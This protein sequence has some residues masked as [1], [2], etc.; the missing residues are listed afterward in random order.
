MPDER[1]AL[2]ALLPDDDYQ[3][4]KASCEVIELTPREFMYEMDAPIDY[5]YFPR[6]LVAS[7]ITV[8][9]DG[10]MAEF[11]TIGRE[12]MV[13]IPAFLGATRAAH[14]AF[15]QVPGETL[16][17]PTPTLLNEV[18]H[19]SALRTILQLY[20]Q[21]LFTQVAQHASCRSVHS[22]E[23]RAAK[24]LLMSHDRVG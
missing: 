4:L 6:S 15:C 21:A 7:M 23:E 10:T 8:M 5:V 16:R 1:N 18:A 13:G 12:G 3:R 11:A 22:V 2:L 24:W 9:Q 20:T 19:S 14:R 17:L